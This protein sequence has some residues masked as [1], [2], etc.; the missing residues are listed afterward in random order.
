MITSMEILQLPRRALCERVQQELRDNPVLRALPGGADIP[1]NEGQGCCPDASVEAAAN[2]GYDVQMLDDWTETLSIDPQVPARF[3]R[4]GSS[5]KADDPLWGKLQEATW[6]LE[7]IELRRR[8][9]EKVIRAIVR[10]QRAVL[11]GGWDL[12]RP[13]SRQQIA[14]RVSLHVTTVS[15]AVDDKWLRTPQGLVPLRQFFARPVSSDDDFLLRPFDP[16]LWDRSS[17]G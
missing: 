12:L 15:R 3:G 13:L 2:G 5:A 16:G 17:K 11:E 10:H 1:P 7:S 8:T 14:D 6:L 4:E 9:L